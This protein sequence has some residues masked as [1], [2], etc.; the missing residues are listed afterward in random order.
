MGQTPSQPILRGVPVH[1]PF[2]GNPAMPIPPRPPGKPQKFGTLTVIFV[3]ENASISPLVFLGFFDVLLFSNSQGL[4]I[5]WMG[6]MAEG[7]FGLSGSPR[8]GLF[9]VWADLLRPSPPC[10]VFWPRKALGSA[11]IWSLGVE[12]FRNLASG[13]RVFF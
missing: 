5:G 7:R 12:D 9:V 1:K 13:K 4:S 8:G 3:R 6:P 11:K 2:F 10:K